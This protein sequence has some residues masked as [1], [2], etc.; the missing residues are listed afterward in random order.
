VRSDGRGGWKTSPGGLVTAITPVLRQRG[1]S[2]VGW[3]GAEGANASDPTAF[4]FDGMSLVNIALTADEAEAYYRQSANEMVWP[5]FHDGVRE[6]RFCHEAWEV[7][8]RINERFA[9][10]AAEVTPEGGTI[11]VQDYHLLLAPGVLRRMR[12]DLKVGL[13]LHIPVPPSDLFM[14]MPW[15]DEVVASLESANLIGT[16]TVH[17]AENLRRALRRVGATAEGHDGNVRAFPISIDSRQVLKKARAADV[18][19]STEE[20]R[21]GLGAEDKTIFLGVDRIDY[22]KGIDKRLEAFELAL[23][24]GDLSAKECRFVQVAVPSR[25]GVGDYDAISERVDT[26]VG[27]IN[28]RFGDGVHGLSDTVV[29]Y[30]KGG[31]PFDELIPLFRAADVMVVTPVRDGM[32]LVAKEY[33]ATRYDG[34]GELILSEFAGASETLTGATSVNPHDIDGLATALGEAHAR[35]KAGRTPEGTMAMHEHVVANDVHAWARSF[36]D[37]IAGTSR[38]T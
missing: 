20:V 7:Y 37:V 6:P 12:P 25:S 11:W 8:K 16:Q 19:G 30:N 24:R 2:W 4:D 22:T 32:N 36:L 35:R 10:A 13:F 14:K 38:T 3:C 33:L 26:L 23:E 9:E 1:G 29:H 21:R 28:G 31:L 15:R 17:D 34:T 5:L 27:R 18:E